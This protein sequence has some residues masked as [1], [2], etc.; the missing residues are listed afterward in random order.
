MIKQKQN[1]VCTSVDQ[2]Y[3]TFQS[4]FLSK[5]LGCRGYT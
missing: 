5:A 1:N 3:E 4:H 2:Q